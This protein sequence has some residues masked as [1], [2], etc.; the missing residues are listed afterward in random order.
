MALLEVV[1]KA[2]VRTNKPRPTIAFP[3]TDPL[4]QHFVALLEELGQ[5]TVLR[6][7]SQ[8]VSIQETWT[9]VASE[10]QGTLASLFGDAFAL[11]IEGTV[12]DTS[13]DL[14]IG[15]FQSDV[16]SAGVR[17]F[18][19][20]GNIYNYEITGGHLKLYPAPPAGLTFSLTIKTVN[21][22]VHGDGTSSTVLKADD[23][24]FL[25]PEMLLI[26]GLRMK[27]LSEK[28]L[29]Y[30][31]QM[32]GFESMLLSLTSRTQTP[33]YLDLNDG[34]DRDASPRIVVQNGNWTL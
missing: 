20:N 5:E 2:M 19:V 18:G 13:T 21:W 1:Q 34:A 27:W 31:E 15:A 14:R 10:D 17:N 28:G 12:Y 11:I 33:K 4:V 24:I 30:A 6:F 22:V 29:P 25:L 23:D 3:N 26:L 7:P 8:A 32:R 9:T 16:T